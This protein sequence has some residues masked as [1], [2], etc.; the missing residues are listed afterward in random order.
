[1]DFISE[2]PD[3]GGRHILGFLDVPTLVQKKVICRSWRTVFIVTIEQKAPIP[4]AFES[5]QE[6]RSAVRKYAEYNPDDA[7]YLHQHMYGP[8]GDGM[9]PML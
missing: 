6:L 3:D 8:L 9:C 1:M 4:K 7:E 5:N 2:L